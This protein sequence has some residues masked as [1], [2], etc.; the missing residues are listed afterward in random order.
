MSAAEPTTTSP[1]ASAALAA[2]PARIREFTLRAVAAGVVLGVVFGA[3]NAYIGLRV[4]ITISSSIP[5]AVLTVAL[6]RA[7][8]VRIG[9][10]EA[11]ISQTV[12]SESTA[13][14]TGTIFT[15]PALYMWE[16]AANPGAV[17][18]GPPYM[19]V[20]SLCFLGALLGI[21]AMIPLR[22][23][24]IVEAHDELPYPEGTAC[25]QVLKAT[26][27]PEGD[28]DLPAEFARAESRARAGRWIFA[29]IGLGMAI[30]I[31]LGMLFLAPSELGAGFA[32]TH[33]Y[34][35]NL[36][37]AL[38]IAPAVIAVG[39]ILGY[40]QSAVILA[41]SALASFAIIPLLTVLGRGLTVPFHGEL[42][43]PKQV[44]SGV[45]LISQMNDGDIWSRYVRYIGAGAVAAAGLVTV[46]RSLP[47]IVKSFGAVAKGLRRGSSAG[48]GASTDRDLPPWFIL[49]A[50]VAVVVIPIA[51]PGIFAGDL[52]AAQRAVC[53]AGV[54]FF[55]ILFVAVAAR[56]TGLVGVSNQPTSAMA[57][58]TLLG[59][60]SAFSAMGWNSPGAQAAV[61]TVGTVVAIAASKSGDASQDMKTGYLVGAT[62]AYQQAG[63]LIGAATACWAVAATVMVL[64]KAYEFGGPDLAAPQATLMKTIIEG[65]LGGMLPWDLV[66]PGAGLSIAA[67]LAGVGGLAFAIGIY[68]P[69]AAMAPIY[70][71]G[72]ARALA[73]RLRARGRVAAVPGTASSR[74][75]E[76]EA[77]E[78]A[79]NETNPGVL[80]ASGLVAGE[81]LAGV[82]VAG[83][84]AYSKTTYSGASQLSGWL[85]ADHPWKGSAGGKTAGILIAVAIVAF[86]VSAG[87][88]KESETR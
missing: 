26:V 25:A 28:G 77:A 75:S 11:N 47:V 51:V 87:G 8:R 64:G 63:Q 2:I 73:D 41:G 78:I 65:V 74:S 1:T 36:S 7:L 40:R 18:Q 33:P 70:L 16:K 20:V 68:L 4:G 37:V 55:G 32:N 34:L 79:R 35:P 19:M 24:L 44:K 5:A 84:A 82:L 17:V 71:G 81:G 72:C 43:T 30:K 56:M 57:L 29:G 52:T 58:L 54:G 31:G 21:A 85:G 22:R 49:G 23:A 69:F 3:A 6:F 10:L 83:L 76:E 15:I 12:A 67:M 46:G 80:A 13:L 50:V 39:Y 14:A 88:R 45:L 62:P 60:A 66:L 53:S 48:D 38:E 61:L 86:L 27:T 59:T 42:F 9:I